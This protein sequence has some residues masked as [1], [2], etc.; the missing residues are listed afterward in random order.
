MESGSRRLESNPG[1]ERPTSLDYNSRVAD[2]VKSR[3]RKF[4][5]CSGD[6]A[7]AA[8][9]VRAGGHQGVKLD[10]YQ[11]MCS[12]LICPGFASVVRP[13]LQLILRHYLGKWFGRRE[14]TASP[15]RRSR[16]EM[17]RCCLR[18]LCQGLRGCV[19]LFIACA[20]GA[21]FSPEVVLDF[22]LSQGLPDS[23]TVAWKESRRPRP[24]TPR[25][26]GNLLYRSALASSFGAPSSVSVPVYMSDLASAVSLRSL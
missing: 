20:L 7:S 15:V 26:S 1:C 21:S 19:S 14:I 9:P 24:S 16:H 13:I 10:G 12:A 11:D 3:G 22:W 6:H 5:Q 17:L 8:S 18:G 2:R 25:N 4:N 23:C